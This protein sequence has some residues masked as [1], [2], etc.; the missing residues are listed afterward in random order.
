M[1]NN[2]TFTYP[3]KKLFN[4]LNVKINDITGDIIVNDMITEKPL[5]YVK[6]TTSEQ[7]IIRSAKHKITESI[8]ML[9]KTF[10]SEI[11]KCD[12]IE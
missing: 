7:S 12:I 9:K 3:E 8:H 1:Q 2:P 4:R 11:V 6:Y 10:V 5:L